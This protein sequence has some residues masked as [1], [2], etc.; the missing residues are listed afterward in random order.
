M[1]LKESRVKYS[2]LVESL[3]IDIAKLSSL[4]NN[5][6]GTNAKTLS[7]ILKILDSA[8]IKSGGFYEDIASPQKGSGFTHYNGAKLA[9]G[10]N[11]YMFGM[12]QE[13][14][15]DSHNTKYILKYTPELNTWE[16]V[17]NID[18]IKK[19]VHSY[20]TD[21]ELIYFVHDGSMYSLDL[22]DYTTK[23]MYNIPEN[24]GFHN[25][26]DFS[27]SVHNGVVKMK[28]GNVVSNFDMAT[29]TLKNL[30]TAPTQD[31][32]KVQRYQWV[33][34][35]LYIVGYWESYKYAKNV[36]LYR[37]SLETNTY[38][39]LKKLENSPQPSITRRD[40]KVVCITSLVTIY[41]VETDTI[42]EE[43]KDAMEGKRVTTEA[44]VSVG[45]VIYRFT[46]G[47]DYG[48]ED[49]TARKYYI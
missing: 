23:G 40:N 45:R 32:Q 46:N 35:D 18:F 24:F 48:R 44:I 42:S 16:K 37:Y 34:S 15:D 29:G 5:D 9:V 11:I 20:C 1:N 6:M 21:G 25:T 39:E 31:L 14:Y 36:V 13:Q 28:N 4:I 49:V 3:D 43:L 27:D 19:G 38:T 17:G 10:G 47:G 8:Y 41:D 7:E 2:E 33:G 26:G 12:Y 22:S 30:K